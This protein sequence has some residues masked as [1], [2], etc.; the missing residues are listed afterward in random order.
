MTTRRRRDSGW[1]TAGSVVNGLLAFVVFVVITRAL[2]AGP[3]AAVS[4]LWSYWAFAGAALTFPVQHWTTRLHVRHGGAAVPP[5]LLPLT[6]GVA[7]LSVLAGGV[8]WLLRGP[9]FER[10]GVA[11]PVMVGLVTVGS[12]A[13]GVVRGQLAGAGRL[14]AVAVSLAGENAVRCAAVLAVA[15]TGVQDPVV[16]GACLVLGHAI[17]LAWPS[18]L[19]MTVAGGGTG[20]VGP[21][22]FLLGAGLAQLV[23]QLLL[24]GGPVVLALVG[25]ARGEVTSLFAALA[26][27][28]AP[29]L[30]ALGLTAQLSA[31]AAGLVTTGRDVAVDV[32]VRRLT[33]GGTALA[34]LGGLL[35]L[36]VGPT[37][38]AGVFGPEAALSAGS[39]GVV[40]AGCTL[41][42]VTLALTVVALARQGAS[43]A[44]LAWLAALA[45][46]VAVFVVLRLAG[47]DETMSTSGGLLGAEVAALVGLLSSARRRASPRPTSLNGPV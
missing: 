47:A 6:G 17:V 7:A 10:D 35:A 27:F 2:G 38:L 24:T 36:G 4:V 22:R 1:L 42:V 14:R 13:V 5:A 32:L 40:G 43:G 34:A 29:Y 3:A 26:L 44:T 30:V 21:A 31:H 39:A 25:A 16:Y 8:A 37:V 33:L 11:F 46:A 15:A 18:M 12:A 19:R 23:H 28:R 41:A 45:V 9:L 20:M